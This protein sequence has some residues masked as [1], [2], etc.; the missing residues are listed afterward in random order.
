MRARTQESPKRSRIG[1]HLSLAN[2]L[3]AML[4]HNLGSRVRSRPES[5]FTRIFFAELRRNTTLEV[6][7]DGRIGGIIFG[8]G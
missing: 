4:S 8:L 3:G 5:F 2:P 1:K 6:K 7:E